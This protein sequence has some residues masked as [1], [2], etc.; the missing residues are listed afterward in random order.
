M[1]CQIFAMTAIALSL[2]TGTARAQAAGEGPKQQGIWIG[3]GFGRSSNDLVCTGCTLTGPADPWRGGKGSSG[4]ATARFAI[5]RHLLIGVEGN[6]GQ[7]SNGART[8][9]IFQILS[10]ATYYPFSRPG[11][12]GPH[13]NVGLGPTILLLENDGGSVGANGLAL[14]AGAGFDIAIRRRFAVTPFANVARTIVRQGSVKP[15]GNA[16]AVTRLD[17]HRVSQFGL[18]LHALVVIP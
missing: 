1:R 4:F 12:N 7:A 9:S 11:V 2:A 15:F 6:L 5:S 17:N 14:R 18:G 8:T 10:T 13:V 3:I 16:G